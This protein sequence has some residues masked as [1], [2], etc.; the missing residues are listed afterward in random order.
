MSTHGGRRPHVCTVCNLCFGRSD[1][2]ARHMKSH[3][4]Q[5]VAAA[6]LA[7]V[8]REEDANI[9]VEDGTGVLQTGTPGLGVS[10]CED[11]EDED[12]DDEVGGQALF[13]CEVCEA[14]FWNQDQLLEHH[15]TTGHQNK[16]PCP[17]STVN[18]AEMAAE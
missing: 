18:V 1:Q 17:M 12:E 15:Q 8:K 3:V 4:A 13:E 7:T 14:S 11:D 5:Q 10:G 2:L 9:Y 16:Q 6:Q